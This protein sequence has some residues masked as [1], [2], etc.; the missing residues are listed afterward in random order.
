MVHQKI[1]EKLKH[2]KKIKVTESYWESIDNIEN[3]K[4][5]TRTEHI[6]D[7]SSISG[8]FVIDKNSKIAEIGV[9][10]KVKK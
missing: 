9:K 4:V 5:T 2:A 1:V 10:E 6:R 8:I 3:Q 7:S